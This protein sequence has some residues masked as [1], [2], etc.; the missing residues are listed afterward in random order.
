MIN[1]LIC[2]YLAY[3]S[4]ECIAVHIL[5]VYTAQKNTPPLQR[6]HTLVI[7]RSQGIY[8]YNSCLF[9]THTLSRLEVLSRTCVDGHHVRVQYN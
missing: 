3:T 9:C 7:N 1:F 5:T 6:M 2:Q 8:M 4:S